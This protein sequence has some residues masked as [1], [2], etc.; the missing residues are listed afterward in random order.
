MIKLV[1]KFLGEIA[2]NATIFIIVT[3][4]TTLF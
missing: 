3:E 2:Q 4:N 1:S